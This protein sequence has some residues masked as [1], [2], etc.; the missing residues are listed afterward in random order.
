MQNFWVKK[1]WFFF[2]FF[3][4]GKKREGKL[5][6]KKFRENPIKKKTKKKEKPL[7]LKVVFDTSRYL[8]RYRLTRYEG[9]RNGSALYFTFS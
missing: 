5:K 4:E 1:L 7:S 9:L 2:F 3:D 8:D 6:K